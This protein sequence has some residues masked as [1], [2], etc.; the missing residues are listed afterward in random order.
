MDEKGEENMSITNDEMIGKLV[1][2]RYKILKR[3]GAGSFGCI[4]SA[5]YENQL[6]AIKLEERDSGRNLLENEAYVMSY[7]NG[8]GLPAVKSY[9]YSS[10]H[11]ILIMELM[12][13]SLE[14]IFE[15]FVSIYFT[16]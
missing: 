4:Y 7:L 6:Y 3:L 14:D 2:D 12:G 10:R 9:G 16:K 8:P 5:E 1:F 11:N 15:S 13:K